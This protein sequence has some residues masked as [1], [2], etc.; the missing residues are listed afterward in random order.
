MQKNEKSKQEV[1]EAVGRHTC[2]NSHASRL[3]RKED[4]RKHT[5]RSDTALA[6]RNDGHMTTHASANLCFFITIIFLVL[7][8][9]L[10]FLSSA[11][12]SDHSQLRFKD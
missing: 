4:R 12:M 1:R 9:L 6:Q 10:F 5:G 7:L 8:C 3:L 11:Q 2:V